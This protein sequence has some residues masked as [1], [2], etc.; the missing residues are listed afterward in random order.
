MWQLC[1]PFGAGEVVEHVDRALKHHEVNWKCLLG[2]TAVT[3][4]TLQDAR[5][6]VDGNSM[7]LLVMLCRRFPETKLCQT[8][9]FPACL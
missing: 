5:Q 9:G 8:F 6:H 2:L 3:L 1:E 4:V 7:S